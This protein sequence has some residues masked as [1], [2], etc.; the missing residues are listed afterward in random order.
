MCNMCVPR[1][2]HKAFHF[3]GRFYVILREGG[4][5]PGSAV[6]TSCAFRRFPSHH[7]RARITPS[8]PSQSSMAVPA[9]LGSALSQ[10]STASIPWATA[11]CAVNG[12]SPLICPRCGNSMRVLAMITDPFRSTG[13][14]AISSRSAVPR[15]GSYTRHCTEIHPQLPRR[16]LSLGPHRRGLFSKIVA[17]LRVH[18]F[19]SLALLDLA[20]PAL[21]PPNSRGP[22]GAPQCVSFLPVVL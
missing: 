11:G 4:S 8:A 7:L 13:S 22:S 16:F 10:R 9:P 15:R 21:A 2:F 12:E 17:G 18:F 1:P 6:P 20:V 19:H 5:P 14:S 3:E